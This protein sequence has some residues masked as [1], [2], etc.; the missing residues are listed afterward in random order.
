MKNN[1]KYRLNNGDDAD[2]IKS[3]LTMMNLWTR[4]T[5]P[6][7]LVDM[8]YSNVIRQEYIDKRKKVIEQKKK[9]NT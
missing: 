2:N 7:T 1:I 5:L 8:D 4:E 9:E 3:K 6:Y